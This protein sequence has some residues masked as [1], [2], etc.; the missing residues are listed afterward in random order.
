MKNHERHEALAHAAFAAVEASGSEMSK[1]A[2]RVGSLSER[3]RESAE[4]VRKPDIANGDEHVAVNF[5]HALDTTVAKL[6]DLLARQNKALQTFNIVLF[7]RTGAG[8][9]TL[10]SAMTR[11]D[12]AAVSQGESDWTT[13]VEPL[14]WHSCRIY[15][16]PGING[17]GRTERRTDLEAR[18]RE[19]VEVADFVIVCFDSQSQQADE[20]T[21]LAEWVKAYRKPIIAVLNPRNAV[22]RLP[23]RVPVGS[24]RAN[25]SRAV[26]EH[27]S[28]I[29]D[30]L[31]KIGLPDV[32]IVA[33]SSKRALFARASLPFHGPDAL[34]LDTQREQYGIEQLEAWSG[35]PRLETLLV[36]AISQHAVTFRLGALHDQLRGVFSK[37]SDELHDYETMARQGAEVL[38][39]DLIGVLL[40]LLGYPPKDNVDRRRPFIREGRDL[41]A[42]LEYHRKGAFQAGVDGEFRQFIRQRLDAELG[43]LRSRAL[44]DAEECIARAFDRRVAVSAND[45]RKAVFDEPA[46]KRAADRVLAEGVKFIE[47]RAGLA[48]RDAA[49][50]LTILARASKVDGEAGDRWKIGGWALQGGGIL[51]GVAGGLGTLA[52][53]N[54]WNPLGWG[55]AV[56]FG[57]TVAGSILSTAFGWFGKKSKN[58][59]E[60]ERLKSRRQAL[61]AIRKNVHEAYDQYQ[62]SILSEVH[63]HAIAVSG[64]ALIRPVEQALLLRRVEHHCSNLRSAIAQLI[65]DLPSTINPQNLL[66]DTAKNIEFSAFPEEPTRSRLY[67]LGEDWIADPVGL[68]HA[69]GPSDGRGTKAYDPNIFDR[70]FVGLKGIFDQV[71]E[72]LKP[73]SGRKW[74]E[75]A[76]EQNAD[77][78]EALEALSELRDIAADG[79]ARIHLVGDYN[80]GKSSFIKR[81]LL[82]AGS[83][84]P[85]SLQIRANPTTDRAQEYDWDGV[86][87]ID[88]PGFQSGDAT[89]TEHAMRAFPDA[90]A[91]IYLF[92]PNLVLGDDGHLVKILQGDEELG[93]APKKERTFFVINRCDE[94]GVDPEMD[95]KA[96]E[97]LVDRKKLELSQALSSRGVDI[98]PR[99]IFCMASDP[100][101]LVG[102]RTDVD[103]TA[104]D[105]YRSWDG[106][107]QFMSEFRKARG[108]LLRAGVDRSVLEGGI[109]RLAMLETRQRQN[110]DKLTAQ[111]RAI[112]RLQVQI[113]EAI[114]EGTRLRAQHRADL[115]RLVMDHAAGFRDDILSETDSAQLEVKVKRFEKWWTDEALQVELGQWAK[116]TAEEMNAWSDR[117]R[118]AIERRL[119]SPEFR[120]AFGDHVEAA[121]DAADMGD[122]TGWGRMLGKASKYMR[123]A[124]RDIVYQAGKAVGFKFKPW[125]AVKLARNVSKVGAVLAVIGIALEVHEIF[126]LEKRIKKREEVRLKFSEFLRESVP[127]VV[128]TVAEGTTE[129][130]G[131]LSHLNDITQALLE[132]DSAQ[133][134]EREAIAAQLEQVR[135]RIS[136]YSALRNNACV[137]LGNPWG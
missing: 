53:A 81:L 66:W 103:A 50:D 38:E 124:T 10:I 37:L 64:Q 115:E 34:S 42:D 3:L 43:T 68:I 85:E 100:F 78:I 129:E 96:Y 99:N 92:Q 128:D 83:A 60:A 22:W 127:R 98:D 20:F 110:E 88:S 59:A 134:T 101:G 13:K 94:L 76:L 15:D 26:G 18:A 57:A 125:G 30:E 93:L 9:S 114:A 49:L 56:A 132:L 80:A 133:A 72:N 35:F 46:M 54:I 86:R 95:Q 31:N 120:A 29:R 119:D 75:G 47:N 4:A 71:T 79:R 123:G 41:L 113:N 19:A 84:I 55:A 137:L 48:Q 109:A 24:A 16:T 131:V 61:A 90:S 12:G 105:S 62:D 52:L 104:F 107:S 89:H 11:G 21:K 87:L 121:P 77:D 67:W 111:D 40:K 70:L 69:E 2:E 8:K 1:V 116:I 39:K 5:A 33:L 14:E 28:N 58:K 82:D 130:P 65:E 126:D 7:G 17:W 25:L 74:L 112:A 117:S 102:S 44:Q 135:T 6:S 108:S 63:K 97:Q 106:F 23:P 27:A 32:P 73:G 91:V 122:K 36:Q 51:A 136:T 118:E 45:V